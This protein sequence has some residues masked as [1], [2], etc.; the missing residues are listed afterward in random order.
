MSVYYLW[1]SNVINAAKRL[2]NGA[3]FRFACADMFL[4]IGEAEGVDLL[5]VLA[6]FMLT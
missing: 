3:Y 4:P 5:A 1:Y 2:L 6:T